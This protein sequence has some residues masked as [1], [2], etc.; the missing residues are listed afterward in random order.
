MRT[1]ALMLESD[2]PGGAEVFL[3]NFALELRRRGHQVVPLLPSDKSGWLA[4]RFREQGFQV[5]SVPIT[6]RFDFLSIVRAISSRLHAR[7]VDTLHSHEFV[8]SFLGTAVA[9]RLRVPHVMTLHANMWMTNAWHRR[10]ILRWAIRRST[11][12]TSVSDHFREHLI[13][14]VGGSARRVTAIPNGIPTPTGDTD[15]VRREFSLQSDET[16]IVATGN[17]TERKGHIHLLRA[18]AK[19]RADGCTAP[20]RVIIAGEGPER[21]ALEAFIA[22]SGLDGL[23]HLP[24]VRGDIGALVGASQI[25]AMPSLWEGMPLSI[26]EGMHC[27]NA[28]VASNVGG[29]PETVRDGVDGLLTPPADVPALAAALRQLLEDPSRRQRMGQAAQERAQREFSISGMMDRYEALYA[30]R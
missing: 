13:A 3:L 10:A 2:G 30:G 19:L 28:I 7:Q 17:L 4:E 12:A 14:T 23:V 1:V 27:A 11:A 9:R 20:L 18:I 29:I 5:E 15:A 26:L 24:G 22:S 8:M 25:L 21:A 6:R 16:V